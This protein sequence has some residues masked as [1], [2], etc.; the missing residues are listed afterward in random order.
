[1][2]ISTD[3]YVLLSSISP[4]DV[5]FMLDLKTYLQS[6]VCTQTCEVFTLD[7]RNYERLVSKRNPRT[8]D[9]IRHGAE[10]KL[11][12]RI[13]RLHDNQVPLLRTLLF[14]MECIDRQ[15]QNKGRRRPMRTP[16]SWEDDFVPQR[17]PLIDMYGPGTVFYRTKMREK[18]KNNVRNKAHFRGA[19]VGFPM[20]LSPLPATVSAVD[21]TRSHEVAPLHGQH[22]LMVPVSRFFNPDLVDDHLL[23]YRSSGDEEEEGE[24]EEEG[25]G[26][27][28][29][30]ADDDGR[31]KPGVKP[32]HPTFSDWKSSDRALSVLE[33][34]ITAWHS[35]LSETP[36]KP[37]KVTA[38]AAV[39]LRRVTIEVLPRYQCIF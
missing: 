22:H 38:P 14:K 31:P 23:T 3:F 11:S 37:S 17:G 7:T 25:G 12:A 20:R 15:Q 19:T 24:G 36:A 10:V 5:E 13:S 6:F 32:V 29:D 35:T 33:D 9:L 30:S 28:A 2:K 34:R 21:V 39:K 8:K 26:G 18:A 4:G 16:I 1:M 27:S